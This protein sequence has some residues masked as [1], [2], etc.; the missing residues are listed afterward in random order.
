MTSGTWL[1][2]LAV[3]KPFITQEGGLLHAL[4]QR[5]KCLV[6][7][8][9][10]GE[11]HWEEHL[12]LILVLGNIYKTIPE[13]SQSSTWLI[14]FRWASGT[15]HPH[16]YNS[17]SGDLISPLY[18]GMDFTENL[19]YLFLFALH[20]LPQTRSKHRDAFQNQ[21]G[22]DLPTSRPLQ[23]C[24]PRFGGLKVHC[25]P[26]VRCA[27]EIG[28]PRCIHGLGPSSLPMVLNSKQD[29]KYGEEI[30]YIIW[31]YKVKHTAYSERQI[32]LFYEHRA[33]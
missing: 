22:L 29:S 30:T 19:L 31:R 33:G 17:Y 10:G 18:A 4:S 8:V 12:V 16:A 20:N 26:L 2:A 24:L 25:G 5:P 9:S 32:A 3:W 21:E 15:L 1:S 23:L 7:C 13:D 28:K 14:L 6:V 27:P 11:W